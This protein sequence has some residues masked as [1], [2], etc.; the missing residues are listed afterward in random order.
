MCNFAPIFATEQ[1]FCRIEVFIIR[2]L[3]KDERNYKD[4]STG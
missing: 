1:I 2:C 3:N 4:P